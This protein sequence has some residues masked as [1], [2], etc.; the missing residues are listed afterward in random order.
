MLFPIPQLESTALNRAAAP[1]GLSLS[2]AQAAALQRQ[3]GQ[4]LERTGRLCFGAS[5]LPRLAAAFAGSPYVDARDWAQTLGELAELFYTL[6]NETQDALSDEELILRMARTFDG[7]AQGSLDLLTDFVL[8]GT[9]MPDP[10]QEDGD[11]ED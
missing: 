9:L 10:A 3:E 4:A 1:F 11:D 7:P 8:D 6:K 5:I 2:P